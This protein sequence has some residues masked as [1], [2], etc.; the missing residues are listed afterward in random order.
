M[1]TNSKRQ[2]CWLRTTTTTT[3]TPE[4]H[5][6]SMGNVKSSAAAAPPPSSSS[7]SS[8]LSLLLLVEPAMRGDLETLQTRVDD[9]VDMLAGPSGTACVIQAVVKRD[10]R[11]AA[12]LN[13]TDSGGNAAI[14]GAVFGGHLEVVQYLTAQGASLDIVNGLGCSPVWLAAGYNRRE[15][16]ELLLEH[17]HSAEALTTPNNT[18]D[19]PLLA[20]ASKGHGEICRLLLSTAV[21]KHQMDQ[22][23]LVCHQNDSLDTPLSVA[24]ANGFGENLWD[25]LYHESVVRHANRSGLTPL[26]IAC[27]RN[28]ADVARRCLLINEQTKNND[29]ANDLCAA[30]DAHGNSALAVAA[31]CGSDQVVECLLQA[32]H[33]ATSALLLNAASDTTG[34]TPLWLATGPDTPVASKNCSRP[35]LMLVGL[36]TKMVGRPYKWPTSTNDGI[37]PSCCCCRQSKR[38]QH[39]SKQVAAKRQE[40]RALREFLC[41]LS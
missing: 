30:R 6:S 20:A 37:L 29:E 28:D 10:P 1:C 31:F 40:L 12:F 35:V 4:Y 36:T 18:G 13:Q 14:H 26:L 23:T 16:L 2:S 9:F 25:L 8:S 3:T 39:S 24:I 38:K 11:L 41:C 5:S 17:V 15:V 32:S 19:S 22:N 27:E 7:S 34:C 33:N 21:K